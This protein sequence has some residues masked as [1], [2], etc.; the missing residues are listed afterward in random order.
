MPWV[1]P[2]FSLHYIR[3]THTLQYASH[4]SPARN[5][6]HGCKWHAAPTKNSKKS[7]VKRFSFPV[8]QVHAVIG[9]SGKSTFG[10][11]LH[12]IR[13]AGGRGAAYSR[14]KLLLTWLRP[15]M[16]RLTEITNKCGMLFFHLPCFFPLI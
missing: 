2:P 1:T 4:K 11:T 5:N 8:Q 14:I 13:P 6:T 9:V 12:S 3:K 15:S 7:A 16:V 10:K